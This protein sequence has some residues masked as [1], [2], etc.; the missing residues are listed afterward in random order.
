MERL[1]LRRKYTVASWLSAKPGSAKRLPGGK[2]TWP[3]PGP[4]RGSHGDVFGRSG[5]TR[6]QAQPGARENP[7]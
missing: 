4:P 2:L 5:P 6:E 3:L 7:R 1:E